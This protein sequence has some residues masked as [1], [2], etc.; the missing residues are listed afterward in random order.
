MKYFD[1]HN[2]LRLTTLYYGNTPI[3]ALSC[4][5]DPANKIYNAYLT[6]YD[7][8]YAHLSPGIVLFAE[9]IKYAIEKKFKFYDLTLGLDYYKLSF[10]PQQFE[11]KNLRIIRKGI[12]T[13]LLKGKSKLIKRLKKRA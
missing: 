5:P 2:L 12:R 1:Q 13:S 11:T 9:S 7:P 3:A 6:A 8:Q 4:I 10:R